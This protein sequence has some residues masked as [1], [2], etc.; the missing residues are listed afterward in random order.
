M[1]AVHD[2]YIQ[3]ID[4]IEQYYLAATQQTDRLTG[5]PFHR[6]RACVRGAEDY[7]PGLQNDPRLF[8]DFEVP[9]CARN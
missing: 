1:V 9:C 8:G 3:D 6:L 2:Y 7:S 5:L 4:L